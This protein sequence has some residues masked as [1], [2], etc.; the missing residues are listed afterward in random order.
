MKIQVICYTASYSHFVQAFVNVEIDGWL[1][2]NGLN[3]LRDGTLKSAQLTHYVGNQRVYHDAVEI[4]DDDLRALL[5]ADILAA[6]RQHIETLPPEARI[7]LPRLP[8]TP[9][10]RAKPPVT[11][12]P[13]PPL[14]DS[15]PRPESNG[16]KRPLPPPM[17]LQPDRRPLFRAGAIRR[18]K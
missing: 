2:F 12:P 1:R 16:S 17:R 18:S 9:E 6:I 8:R 3:L 10:Q 5:A 11:P 14:R 7:R 15:R 4:P 13:R